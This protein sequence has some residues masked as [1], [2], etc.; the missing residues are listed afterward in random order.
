[1][2]KLKKFG[3]AALASLGSFAVMAEGG[4]AGADT[5]NAADSI[6][7]PAQNALTG[8]LTS[9]G[10]AVASILLAGLAIW[11]GIAIVGLIKRSFNAGKGR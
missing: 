8:V 4:T 11:G 3:V 7:T 2:N 10:G 6:I 9:A 5:F 1:M